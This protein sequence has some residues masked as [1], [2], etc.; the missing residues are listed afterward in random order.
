MYDD[1][2][3]DEVW[4]FGTTIMLVLTSGESVYLQQVVSEDGLARIVEVN[5]TDIKENN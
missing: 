5:P 2:Y 3:V 4:Y 1:A